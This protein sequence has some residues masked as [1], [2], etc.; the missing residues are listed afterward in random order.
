MTSPYLQEYLT[1][2]KELRS[3]IYRLVAH[4]QETE[5]IVQETYLKVVRKIDSF[6]G[7]GSFKAWVFTIAA[8]LAKDSLKARQRWGEDWMEVVKDAHVEDKTLLAKKFEVSRTSEHGKYVIREHINYCFNCVS[9]TLLLTNQICL[10]LKEVYNFKIQ[11]ITLITGLSEGKVK[12][13]IANSRSDMNRIFK[14]RCALVNKEGVCH[15]CTGLN[16]RFNPDQNT[17]EEANKIKMIRESRRK[18]HDEL[19]NLRLQLVKGIDPLEAEG[20]DLHNYLIE[21]SPEWAKSR[22]ETQ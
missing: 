6:K 20:T 7:E 8:N 14:K 18:N 17:Q 21:N 4:R 9:K 11:E 12:H 3:F 1:F 13:A 2:Q 15:Q 19:L 22:L 16:N 10:L 5:D